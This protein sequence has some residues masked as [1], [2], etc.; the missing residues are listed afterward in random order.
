ALVLQLDQVEHLVHRVGVLVQAVEQRHRLA[1]RQLLG[2]LGYNQLDAEAL[3]Q[4]VSA[5]AVVPVHAQD[6]DVA[7]VGQREAFENFDGRG[8]AGAV[9]AQ[10]AEALAGRDGEVE[11]VHGRECA[12]ALDE[13][14]AAD[15]GRAQ[16]GAWSLGFSGS[17][18]L[19]FSGARA[20]LSD[21]SSW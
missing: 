15:R 6:F 4:G 13:P 1:N 11:P 3:A 18:A 21:W 5:R 12:V 7:R 19:T 8:L 17:G 9:R 2:E 16:A 14:A 20:A 10:Q